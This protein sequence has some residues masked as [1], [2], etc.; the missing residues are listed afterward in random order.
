MK[1][2]IMR[3]QSGSGKSTYIRQYCQGA[4]VVSADH[5]FE[6]GGRYN[7]NPSVLG[8][9][10]A[11]CKH[12]FQTALDARKPLIVVDNTNTTVKEMK[13]YHD[14]A[15]AAGYEV[16]VVTLLVD[17]KVSH[18]RNA[19]GVPF[20]VVVKQH[21]RLKDTELPE[22]WNIQHIVLNQ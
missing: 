6:R 5:F 1:V 2:I 8:S 12:R 7:F 19:H 4:F 11:E 15:C 17:P 20:E 13:P 21:E 18:A 9:A 3:G 22:S 14:A 16:V 10:H